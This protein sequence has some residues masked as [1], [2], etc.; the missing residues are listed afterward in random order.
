MAVTRNACIII[1]GDYNTTLPDYQTF[2][3]RRAYYASTSYVDDLIG[4]MMNILDMYGLA[5]NTVVVFT[6]D[7][8]FQLGEHAE[9]L[10]QTNFELATRTVTMIKVPGTC[11]CLGSLYFPSC[12]YL[13]RMGM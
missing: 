12:I 10:K 1:A 13:L 5:D 7:H 4:Q 11:A 6:S 9:W 8:G 3:M 2:E